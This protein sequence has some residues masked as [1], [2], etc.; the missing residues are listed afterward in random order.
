LDFEPEKTVVSATNN[1]VTLSG[2]P[3]GIKGLYGAYILHK[4]PFTYEYE[5][6]EVTYTSLDYYDAF[7]GNTL[8]IDRPS[9]GQI[10]IEGGVEE[11]VKDTR[12][13]S[14]VRNFEFYKFTLPD[15]DVYVADKANFEKALL[16]VKG[17]VLMKAKADMTEYEKTE[18]PDDY[19]DRQQTPDSYSKVEAIGIGLNEIIAPGDE[20]KLIETENDD[21]LILTADT[22]KDPVVTDE[23]ATQIETTWKL[24]NDVPNVLSAFLQKLEAKQNLK[25]SRNWRVHST[26]K[27]NVALIVR[28]TMTMEDGKEL[29]LDNSKEGGVYANIGTMDIREGDL[30]LTNTLAWDADGKNGPDGV[31]IG[32][33]VMGG[34][35]TLYSGDSGYTVDNYN[36]YATKEGAE[37]AAGT[38]DGNLLAE[39]ANLNFYLPNTTKAG[40]TFLIVKNGIAKIGGSTV[41]IHM[42]GGQDPG[43]VA[44]DELYLIDVEEKDSENDFVDG[45]PV[46]EDAPVEVS[47]D[48]QPDNV[49]E[50]VDVKVGVLLKYA[51]KLK[52]SNDRLIAYLEGAAPPSDDDSEPVVT[53]EE[54][55]NDD[56]NGEDENNSGNNKGKGNPHN[57]TDD[58]DGTENPDNTNT[59]NENP[60]D[61][62]IPAPEE[63]E[64]EEIEIENPDA[65]R[66]TTPP[67]AKSPLLP[68][69]RSFAE[70]YLAG[71]TLLIQGH[72][73]LTGALLPKTD[74]FEYQ[75]FAV[76]GGA[77][78][79]YNVG[80]HL[81]LK[82]FSVLAGISKRKE[83][84]KGD[85]YFGPF[86][87]YGVGAYHTRDVYP[88][89]GT[90]NGKGTA[91]Y[92]GAGL[93]ARY[94]F[95]ETEDGYFYLEGSARAGRLKDDYD[96]KDLRDYRG[97]VAKYG[98][99]SPYY[100]FHAGLGYQWNLSEKTNL[101]LSA[102]YYYTKV[103]GDDVQLT[104]GETINFH[105]A[106][107]SRLQV[108]A[109]LS[110]KINVK[111]APYAAL[112]FEREY[113]GTVHA[114]TG[115]YGFEAPSLKGNTGIGEL[116]F[117]WKP[118]PRW[119]IDLGV[120]GYWGKRE[121][122]A[123]T[124]R[125][126]YQW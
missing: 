90:V 86:V 108:R 81:G 69:S 101:D 102:K 89:I 22:L 18:N 126:K 76:F 77:N 124:L 78:L 115:R 21:D 88:E 97:V 53:E 36:I 106:K 55:K 99:K 47:L 4:T 33:L 6:D 43:F 9:E 114:S 104:T 66:G 39:G 44:E 16:Y 109:K 24:I 68:Q 123:A 70:G 48:G 64:I 63:P 26:E 46:N 98:L 73:L 113:D 75:V 111:F 28:G 12:D 119:T 118:K 49:A 93:L 13:S 45:D 91:K 82:N 56:D 74:D 59:G 96:S 40:D 5:I 116:G 29:H 41:A 51:F 25:R 27:E 7:T 61:P 11:P 50:S 31:H 71:L 57:K 112:A 20:V 34:G 117:T 87:E 42:A 85:L 103:K 60:Q 58:P 100:G 122:V 15:T 125:F 52:T 54:N 30:R 14:T 35:H 92:I 32:T 84:D 110:R 83:Y 8:H 1:T 37:V 23:D 79:H 121:G 94:N 107:S 120:Q 3:T 17:R 10:V 62:V 80:G 67:K 105:P 95:K 19:Y 65:G 72:G 2:N 38:V